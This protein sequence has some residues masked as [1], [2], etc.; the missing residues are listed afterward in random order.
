MKKNSPAVKTKKTKKTKKITE[1]MY[2]S[3]IEASLGTI[4]DVS[5]RLNIT[6]G[7]V[8]QYLDKHHEIK[9]LLASKRMDNVSLAEDVLFENLKFD[10]YD[11][12]PTTAA[13]V[14][15]D[16]AKY[17]TGRLGKKQGWVEKQEVGIETSNNLTK[18]QM[19]EI[20]NRL[21]K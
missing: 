17:I 2:R 12:D 8:C 15:Q 5:V 3:A 4:T 11:K 7:A 18:E 6:T 1:Q 13:R 21:K 19:N 16:S 10:D 20:I 9:A 14:R